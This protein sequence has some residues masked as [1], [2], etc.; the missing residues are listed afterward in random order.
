M[1]KRKLKSKE[2]KLKEFEV[3]Y[4]FKVMAEDED[5]AT[6]KLNKFLPLENPV[7]LDYWQIAIKPKTNKENCG[8]CTKFDEYGC[9]WQ[10]IAPGECDRQDIIKEEVTPIPKK[11][12]G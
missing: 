2:P 4:F 7:V 8:T 9:I 3:R 11:S 6:K 1:S 12:K 5:D 10:F